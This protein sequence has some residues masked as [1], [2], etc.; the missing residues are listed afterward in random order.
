MRL[1][2]RSPNLLQSRRNVKFGGFQNRSRGLFGGCVGGGEGGGWGERGRGRG[3]G[4][5]GE[6]RGSEW[7]GEGRGEMKDYILFMNIYRHDIYIYIYILTF[8]N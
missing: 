4:R 7:S 3:R 6:E 5:E 1:R 2:T 8:F